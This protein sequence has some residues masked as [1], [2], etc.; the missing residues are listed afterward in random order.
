[1]PDSNK[2]RLQARCRA[3]EE[4]S[5]IAPPAPTPGPAPVLPLAQAPRW[6][7]VPLATARQP[8]AAV[9]VWAVASR[10]AS[11]ESRVST[12]AIARLGAMS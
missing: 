9:L 5:R 4:R 8:G 3:L 1:M 10:L 12:V 7:P 6:E 11:R 2:E